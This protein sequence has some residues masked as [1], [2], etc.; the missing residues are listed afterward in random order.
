MKHIQDKFYEGERSLFKLEDAYIKNCIFD[1]GES[2]LK[3]TKDLVIESTSFKWKYPLWY[4][5]NIKLTSCYFFENARAGVWYTDDAEFVNCL[6]IAPKQFRRCHNISLDH[7]TFTNAS[8]TLWECDG[9]VLN[10]TSVKGDYLLMNSK[11]I[12]VRGLDL[13][14]NYPF[15]GC[16]NVIVE[17]SKLITKDAFWN[18]DSVIVRNSYISG[19]YLAWNSKNVTF[20]NCVIESH[21]GLCYMKNLAMKDCCLINTDLSF[22]YSENIC[23]SICSE[24]DSV[25][26][27]TS[28]YIKAKHIKELIL[29]EADLTKIRIEQD[30]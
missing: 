5:K 15:D 23:A 11:N 13:E 25:K 27:P 2:P 4:S 6:V 14:G 8:E 7:I 18:C 16:K 24:I 3:E 30:E 29:D 10:D 26:N 28:G 17:N 19:E 22:E 20:E 12:R 21:Q 9:V 1:N